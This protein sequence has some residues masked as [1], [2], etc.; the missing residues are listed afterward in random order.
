MT[1][2]DHQRPSFSHTFS[3]TSENP[4]FMFHGVVSLFVSSLFPLFGLSFSLIFEA[5]QLLDAAMLKP[6]SNLPISLLT[7]SQ[8]YTTKTGLYFSF[9]FMLYPLFSLWLSLWDHYPVD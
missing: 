3:S 9:S 8:L 6:L 7:G 4:I 1:P 5:E 2:H